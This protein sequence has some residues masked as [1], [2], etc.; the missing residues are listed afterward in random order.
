[1]STSSSYLDQN[2]HQTQPAMLDVLYMRHQSADKQSLCQ[3]GYRQTV[4]PVAR[5]ADFTRC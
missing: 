2:E 5:Q 1:M 3:S 4:C